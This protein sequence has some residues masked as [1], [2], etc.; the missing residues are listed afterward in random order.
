MA[1]DDSFGRVKSFLAE[2]SNQQLLGSSGVIAMPQTTD[3]DS[4]GFNA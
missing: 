4:H 1:A 3:G 2:K